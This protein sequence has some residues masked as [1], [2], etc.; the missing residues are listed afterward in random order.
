MPLYGTHLQHD[1]CCFFYDLEEN[2]KFEYN[3]DDITDIQKV[4]KN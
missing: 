2:L 3:K 4:K 1:C